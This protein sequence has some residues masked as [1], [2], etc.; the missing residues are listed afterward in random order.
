MTATT[1]TVTGT[2]TAP[3]FQQVSLWLLLAFVASL[4]VSIAAASVLLA[5][6]LVCW[7]ALLVREGIRPSA[8]R[9]F[10]PLSLYAGMTLLSAA[11]SLEPATSFLDS[12]QLVVFLI[13]PAVYEIV[14]GR[15]A[16]G[17]VIDVIVTIGGASAAYGIIQYGILQY[18]S[19]Q[20]RPQGALSHYMTYSGTLMLVICAAVARLVFGS[21]DRIWSALVMPALV[22]ALAVSLAR[23]AWVGACVA[24]GLLLVL[25]D[26]R[27]TA[28]LPIA[29]AVVFALAPDSVTSRIMTMF[30]AQDRTNQDRFAMM[31]IGARIVMDDPLTGVGPNMV[32]KVYEQYRPEYAVERINPHLHNVPLQIAAERGVPAFAVWLWFVG[33]LAL[34]L[35]RL[36]RQEPDDR[37]LAGA[38]LAAVAAMLAA[39]F[40][41]YNFGDSEFLML[42]LVLVTL[43]FAANK[44]AAATARS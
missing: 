31:E 21:R 43:P 44:D 38:G 5:A 26:F 27:L 37:M 19:L 32:P 14:R 3:S 18:D 6:V 23:N 36:F 1:M 39:G 10:V 30:D 40:F 29:I 16:A 28:L 2:R 42:F 7:M 4:Q 34:S 13:V 17:L 9:F 15:R 20:L 33:A 41:E 25:K 8:P 22:V 12:K 11:F 35:I 24:I